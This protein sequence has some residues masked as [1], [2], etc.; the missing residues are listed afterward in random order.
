MVPFEVPKLEKA[1]Q[2]YE[3]FHICYRLVFEPIADLQNAAFL[4]LPVSELRN[5]IVLNLPL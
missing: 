4:G 5:Q 1:A 2:A 3:R